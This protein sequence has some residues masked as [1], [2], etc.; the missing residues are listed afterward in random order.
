MIEIMVK[1]AMDGWMP[2]STGME[3]LTEEQANRREEVG[4]WI[5]DLSH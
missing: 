1:M 3:Q 4:A 2:L 5:L